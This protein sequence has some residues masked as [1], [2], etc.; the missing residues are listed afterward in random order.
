MAPML[1]VSFTSVRVALRSIGYLPLRMALSQALPPTCDCSI[2]ANGPGCEVDGRQSRNAPPSQACWPQGCEL[3]G[4]QADGIR[5][6]GACRW[7]R[8]P[9]R[10]GQQPRCATLTGGVDCAQA[11]SSPLA[12]DGQP[13]RTEELRSCLALQL[14]PSQAA[15]AKALLCQRALASA[16]A[17]AWPCISQLERGMTRLG[18][19]KWPDG[20][21]LLR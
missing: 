17:A 19:W 16:S 10:G 14:M 2:P 7:P 4:C 3:W 21:Q 15:T 5:P 1:N 6:N 20:A 12:G 13:Q 18:N 9:S 11:G 8:R